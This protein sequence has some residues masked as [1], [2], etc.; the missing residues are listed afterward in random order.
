MN[1]DIP[2]LEHKT[3]SYLTWEEG[4]ETGKARAVAE[5]SKA[6]DKLQP[7]FR[8]I[9]SD[10]WVNVLPPS[11]SVRDGFSR[12]DYDYFRPE[13]AH[14]KKPKD[15]IKE[16]RKVAK[17]VGLVKNILSL[18]V[19]FAIQGIDVCHPNEQVEKFC[20]EWFRAVKG[21]ELS[22]KFLYDVF[23]SGQVFVKRETGRISSADE[24]QMRRTIAE[25][26][27]EFAVQSADMDFRDILPENPKKREVP[28]RYTC[29]NPLS[30]ECVTDGF[31]GLIP[32]EEK[33][34]AVRIP[35]KII[36]LLKNQFPNEKQKAIIDRIP[37]TIKEA[38]LNGG[39]IIL[40]SKILEVYHYKKED[41]EDW[42]EPLIAAVL[43]DLKMLE[44]MKLADLAALDGA[45]SNVRIWK[46]GS[47]EHKILPSEGQ[48]TKLAEMLANSVGGGV[49]DITW[50]PDIELLTTETDVHHFL[51]TTKYLPVLE[52]IYEGLGVPGALTGR[53]G[54]SG[55]TNNFLSLKTLIERL[56]YG[57]DLLIEFWLKELRMVQKALGFRFCPSVTFDRMTL[58][59]E[60]AE[61]QLL[62]NLWD[63]VLVSDES[64]QEKFGFTPEIEKVRI[65]REEKKRANG[66]KPPRASP[67]HDANHHKALE[68][69][70][71]QTSRFAPEDFGLELQS[72][73]ANARIPAKEE[74]KRKFKEAKL[75]PKLPPGTPGTPGAKPGVAKPGAAKPKPKSGNPE[76]GRPKKAADT[77][78]R[79]QK[80]IRP[81]QSVKQAK[82]AAWV[83]ER[84]M[85]ILQ[86]KLPE[87]TLESQQKKA[88]LLALFHPPIRPTQ[89][90][91]QESIT[92]ASLL[93]EEVRESYFCDFDNYISRWYEGG[94]AEY[95]AVYDTLHGEFNEGVHA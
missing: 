41:S 54:E 79:K 30:M 61:K 86:K 93:S 50:G 87:K 82:S 8:A 69:I 80:E 78:K 39:Q 91:L 20:K 49:I 70:Y 17:R 67:F 33:I 18:M 53:S 25:N 32:S 1:A 14:P 63:R 68:R 64:I 9:G 34:W 73:E 77:K 95:Y 72:D 40:D 84:I 94:N 71:A 4:D 76:G 27:Q 47:L 83:H 92:Q 43:P 44:K 75:A 56:Q 26:P 36:N 60:A 2:E 85:R 28:A 90:T 65:S 42:A 55:F 88:L 15:L 37:Q 81:R 38:A 51:G 6:V 35:A 31:S 46:L 24:E 48:L 66:K 74:D 12:E 45:I 19:D 13:E 89:K 11:T 23:A 16:C 58:N 57:R 62:L 52:S 29:L 10:I 21:K 3:T 22:R 7:R 5:L 59:D